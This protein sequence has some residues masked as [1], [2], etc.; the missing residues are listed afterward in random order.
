MVWVNRVVWVVINMEIWVIL[1]RRG[2]SE[3]WEWLWWLCL[4]KV[5]V[6]PIVSHSLRVVIMWVVWAI[7]RLG[8]VRWECVI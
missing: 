3:P 5:R 8:L 1:L 6:M 4:F 7:I 2:K